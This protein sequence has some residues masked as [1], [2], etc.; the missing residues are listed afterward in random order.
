MAK[1]GL[2]LEGGAFRGV[3]TSGVLD[4][5]MENE[6]EYDYVIGVSAGAGN[7]MGYITGQVGRTRNVIKPKDHSQNYFGLKQV[8]RH[9]KFL[10]L[11]KMF[12]E[13]PY[14]QYPY[15]F[16]KFRK[17][18]VALEVVV[19]N[20]DT[21]KA[22]YYDERED[23]DRFLNLGKASCSVPLM[24][25][26]VKIGGYHYL[27][28]SICDSIPL[29]RALEQGCDRLV[30]VMTKSVSETPTNYGK[31]KAVMAMKYKHKYPNFYKAL[32]ERTDVYAKE[33][34]LLKKLEKEGRAIV[35][36]PGIECINKFEQ[37]DTKVEAFYQNGRDVAAENLDILK[38]F[39]MNNDKEAQDK[40]AI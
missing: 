15:D 17:S 35:I 12:F 22:E 26:P 31:A 38:E 11:D 19:S 40:E 30:V 13:Y 6:I 7:G 8:L 32:L 1:T 25:A 2:V 5:L 21:G 10:N 29:E 9:G 34:E 14:K 39:A 27:D 33:L 3:F 18:D 16:D 37:D 28:G 36:R 20:C 23:I 4:V 24:C